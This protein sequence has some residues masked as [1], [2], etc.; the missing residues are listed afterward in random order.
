MDCILTRVNNALIDELNNE[1][2]N[3]HLP[4][5]I[6]ITL[7][8]DVIESAKVFDYGVSRTPEDT[9]KW[10]LIKINPAIEERK[11][12]LL[13]LRLGSVT[14]VTE[15]RLIWVTMVTRPT[16]E[17]KKTFALTRKFNEI[18]EDVVSGDK[19]SHIMKPYL[20]HHNGLFDRSGDLT[21]TG[22]EEY[23][24]QIDQIMSDFETGQ[25]EL[26]PIKHNDRDDRAANQTRHLS[27]TEARRTHRQHSSH[28]DSH[29][30]SHS[31]HREHGNSKYRWSRN[32]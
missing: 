18:L 13:K 25:T 7:D 4:K 5:F 8:K 14:S 21:P 31:N 22:K 11:E 26:T 9:L 23:W 12:N 20:S 28:E 32:Y 3:Y 29:R 24:K 2:H 17:N 30:R 15:P 10:L 6:I 16:C 19:R 1:E 27:E